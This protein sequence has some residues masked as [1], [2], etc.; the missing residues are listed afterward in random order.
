ML[1][2]LIFGLV[3][4]QIIKKHS[5]YTGLNFFVPLYILPSPTL[6]NFFY[7][8]V[9]Y[10]KRVL[11]PKIVFYNR[12]QFFQPKLERSKEK[13]LLYN[14]FDTY[15]TS[16]LFTKHCFRY[17]VS[18]LLRFLLLF[19]QNML[20]FWVYRSV[21]C[22]GVVDRERVMGDGVDADDFQLTSY[23]TVWG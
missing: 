11:Q 22:S 1:I 14:T 4:N 6:Y 3:T 5:H 15:F 12:L 17:S 8:L 9:L 10:N 7:K 2:L 19:R 20:W 16:N 23:R 21:V 13:S 18:R